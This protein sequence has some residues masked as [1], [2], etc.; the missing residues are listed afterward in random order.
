MADCEFKKVDANN[1]FDADYGSLIV[2]AVAVDSQLS[3][4]NKDVETME[5]I[6]KEYENN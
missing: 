1:K 6:K 3:D 2:L 4:K 5:I